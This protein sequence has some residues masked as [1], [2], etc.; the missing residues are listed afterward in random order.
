M[1]FQN[2]DFATLFSGSIG[3]TVYSHNRYGAYRK[4][5]AI[6]VNP[7]TA[8]QEFVRGLM[9]QFSQEWRTLTP[10]QQQS[11]NT[12][13]IDFPRNDAIGQTITL[14]GHALFVALNINLALIGQ[15]QILDCPVPTPVEG[16][17]FGQIN[18]TAPLSVSSLTFVIEALLT[19]NT[20]NLP[21]GQ[22]VE[23]WASR[24]MSPGKFF[25]K[26]FRLLWTVDGP[27]SIAFPNT[28][29]KAT[30]EATF[31]TVVAGEKVFFILNNIGD[32]T[33]L[34]GAPIKFSTIVQ[35]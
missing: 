16:Y 5:K 33:G 28:F 11:F 6:P 19:D 9:I 13:N 1:K 2:T 12:R 15:P 10:A 18:P 29:D 21:A 31:G 24:N 23:V 30:Y 22:T 26:D 34:K 3:A 14:S 25:N 7:Q 32:P 20:S 8:K 17:I 27:F 35:P 4:L